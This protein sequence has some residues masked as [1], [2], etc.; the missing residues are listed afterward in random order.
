MFVKNLCLSSF[1][2]CFEELCGTMRLNILYFPLS[3]SAHFS[4]FIKK[5]P[6]ISTD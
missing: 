5:E 6:K 1:F 2:R 4:D 3:E